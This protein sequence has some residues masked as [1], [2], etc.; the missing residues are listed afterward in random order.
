MAKRRVKIEEALSGTTTPVFA[1]DAERRILFFNSGCEELTGWPVEDVRWQTCHFASDVDRTSVAAL[2]GT[3]CPPP[4]SF[5]GEAHSVPKFFVHKTSGVSAARM[6]HFFPLS[7]PA[8]VEF[9][10]GVVTEVPQ[11]RITVESSVV[12]QMHAELASLRHSLRARF[13]LKS[14]IAKS[15]AMLRVLDQINAARQSLVTVSVSGPPGSGKEHVARAIHY[16]SKFAGKA[17]VPLDCWHLPAHEIRESVIRIIESDWAEMT[18]IASLQPGAIYLKHADRL[19]REL[20]QRLVDF[21]ST[22]RGAAFRSRVRLMISSDSDLLIALHDGRV[23]EDFYFRVTGLKIEL[24]PLRERLA[25]IRVLAQHFVE[26]RNRSG[27]KQITG[28]SADVWSQLEEYNWP[29]NLDEL[30]QVISDAH[31]A[32]L[33]TVIGSDHLPF[34]FRTGLD[35]QTQSPTK[36]TTIEPLDELLSRVER[37]QIEAALKQ[38][39]FNKTLACKWLGISRVSL[40]RRMETLGIVDPASEPSAEPKSVLE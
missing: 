17:F 23:S 21:L 35:A 19:P 33:R 1:V 10:L 38:A 5:L 2:T 39:N 9:V 27:E 15:N 3:L 40:Y 24:P 37:Q 30:R 12:G 16:E 22:D 8:G 11:P 28:I 31:T 25:E 4:E 14:M 7:G 29:G 18:P 32:C 13:S 20:Q 26:D 36:P 34:R 6:I